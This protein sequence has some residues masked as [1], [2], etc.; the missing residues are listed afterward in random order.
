MTQ[1]RLLDLRPTRVR[2]NYTGGLLLDAL[3]GELNPADSNRPE[4]WL[5]STTAARNPGMDEVADE[6]LSL[7][8]DGKLLRDLLRDDPPYYLGEH[9]ARGMRYLAKL[10]DSAVR[11]QVQA[12]PTAAF[13]QQHMNSPFGK[14]ESYVI[15]ESRDGVDPYIRLGFQH[16]PSPDEWKRIVLEQDIAAMDACFEKV[17]VK[18]GEVWI[19][20]GGLPHAIGEGL[21]VIEVMEPSD[22]VVRCEFGDP[23]PG[24][25]SYVPPAAR[26]MGCDPDFALRIFDHNSYSVEEITRRCRLSPRK[27]SDHHEQLIG[28]KQTPGFIVDRFNLTADITTPHAD[29]LQLAIVVQGAGEARAGDDSVVLRPGARFVIPAATRAVDWRIMEPTTIVLCDSQPPD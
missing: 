2:R 11:L 19:V 28:A 12:H 18:P 8:T 23:A 21:F 7:T 13:A 26:F 5:A 9:H 27:V 4:D 29:S 16:A 20:P 1:P 17:P 22:L 3:L 10:L 15:L 14:F 25:K 6:G 24:S